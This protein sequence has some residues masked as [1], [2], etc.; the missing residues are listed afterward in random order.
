MKRKDFLKLTGTGAGALLI[1]AGIISFISTGCNKS[2]NMGGMSGNG[3]P[4]TDGEFL[5][6]LPIP[7]S[8]GAN[9]TLAAQTTSAA[10]KGNQSYH[11][12]GYQA[13]S[14]L[15]P[16]FRINKWENVSIN[17][18]NLL[19]EASN[20]HWHGL[21][22]PAAMDGHPANIINAGTSFNYNFIIQQRAGLN[23][24]HPHPHM[25]TG[26]QVY[27]GLAGL[28][29]VNDP[30]EAALNLP[31]G[32]YEIPLVIQDK[33][34]ADTNLTYN[35]TVMEV[36][37]GYLGES[38]LVNGKFSPFHAVKSQTYRLRILNGSNARIY[39]LAFSNDQSFTIIGNDGGLLKTPVSVNNILISPGERLDVLVDFSASNAGDEV[40]LISKVF[41]GGGNAQ[42]NQLFKILKFKITQKMNAP[43][44]IPSIL[45][46]ITPL[47]ATQASRTRNFDISNPG[48]NMQSGTHRINNKLFDENRIDETVSANAI[49]IWQFDNSQGDEPHPMHI[50]G[51]DFQVLQRIGGR[52]SLIASESGWKDTVLVMP[53]EI[54]KVIV[55][56]GSN[57]G[58]FVFHCHNLEHEGDGMMLQY[59]LS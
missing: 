50:H 44:I 11:V 19:S 13:N 49:E 40:F 2:G 48:M 33:R 12:L 34:L 17:V 5:Q 38:I 26:K 27:K 24:Y 54:V 21:H 37:S 39:N 16:T 4:V 30:E 46:S 15:G 6:A 56:F 36:M 7:P 22:I 52:N 53:G 23:W 31:A 14:I 29:I 41:S 45:S 8:I 18:N 55:P 47:T 1:P 20:I 28:F 9:T 32:E 43:F 51:I 10:L 42:G 35:P 57:P 3:V 58:R 59:Q 25:A